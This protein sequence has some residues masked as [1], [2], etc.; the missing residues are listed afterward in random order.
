MRLSVCIKNTDY[1]QIYAMNWLSEQIMHDN[2]TTI[3]TRLDSILWK[4][5][6]TFLRG[7]C[8]VMDY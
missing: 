2:S 5:L 3:P 6:T 8:P 7:Y 1:Y 4:A